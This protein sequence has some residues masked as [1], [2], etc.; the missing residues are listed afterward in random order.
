MN[1]GWDVARHDQLVNVICKA[2]TRSVADDW[3]SEMKLEMEM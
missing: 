2:V 1:F 3:R